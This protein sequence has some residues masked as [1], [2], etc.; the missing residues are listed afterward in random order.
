MR[1]SITSKAKKVKELI[2]RNRSGQILIHT[3]P[4]GDAIAAAVGLFRII[5][6]MTNRRY[7]LFCPGEIPKR[8]RFLPHSQRFSIRP[9]KT[10][11][12]I[13]LDTA[14]LA[15]LPK[16]KPS[17]LVVNIDH[18]DANPGYGA[19]N[20][21]DTR[22]SSTVEILLKIFEIWQVSIDKTT[23]GALYAGIFAE[24]GGF[25]FRNT[26]AETLKHAFILSNLGASPSELGLQLLSQTSNRFRLLGLVFS[27]IEVKDGVSII[28]ASREMF[29]RTK[30]TIDET[31]GFVE[32]PLL[33]PEVKVSVFLK[34]L[35]DGRT[36]VSLRSKGRI[37]VNRI[38]RGFGGGGHRNA[39][40]FILDGPV[41]VVRRK[42]LER[43][44]T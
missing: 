5:K 21:I 18:H 13:V 9:K 16:W 32:M 27:G 24:T 6:K 7:H 43:I 12:S 44:K 25:V 23:A 8:Y 36:K 41:S 37:D 22:S 15:R 14:D 26:V 39:A 42:I 38:A 19:I 34:E 35:D 31:E 33:I 11:F 17:G 20:I 1:S 10:N 2:L 3:S 30:T 4:D 40:G 29:R 28:R